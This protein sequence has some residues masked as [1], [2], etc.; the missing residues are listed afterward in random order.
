MEINKL[1]TTHTMEY[2][3]IIAKN[4]LLI[5]V[6]IWMILKCIT[7][8][9]SKKAPL[10]CNFIYKTTF[11]KRQNYSDRRAGAVMGPRWGSV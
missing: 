3:S 7:I 8:S 9:K 11:S 1:W 4:E 2:Y 10:L 5:Q 6:I